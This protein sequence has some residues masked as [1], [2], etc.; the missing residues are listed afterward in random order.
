MIPVG[1]QVAGMWGI[2]IEIVVLRHGQSVADIVGRHEGRADFPL[3]DL[4]R[5]QAGLAAGWIAEHL[6]PDVIFASP[7]KRAAETAQILADRLTLDVCFDDDL[8]EFDNGLQAGLTFAE[9]DER[10]PVPEGGYKPHE[11]VPGGESEIAFGARAELAW[12]GL[13][14]TAEQGQRIAIVAHG[15]IITRL[16]RCFLQ[17]PLCT[18]VRA[19]T[20]DTGI[21]LWRVFDDNRYVV[22]MNRSGHL[23]GLGQG[24]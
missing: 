18:N 16:F 13:L 24:A 22:F 8:M 6:P 4:G 7:L 11:R 19:G 9:A 10:Y 1:Y 21:H 14:S 3:T 2:M 23:A 12:S 5:E 20:G 15:G 17:L